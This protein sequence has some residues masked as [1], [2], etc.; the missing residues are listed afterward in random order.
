MGSQTRD[1]DISQVHI[2]FQRHGQA[3]SNIVD[4]DNPGINTEHMTMSQLHTLART[5]TGYLQTGI[6]LPDG[7]TQF[8]LDASKTFVDAVTPN[9]KLDN[10]YMLVSSPLTRAFQTIQGNAPAFN[11]VGPLHT[12]SPATLDPDF[13]FPQNTPSISK[14][15]IYVHAGLQEATTWPQDFP[16][17]IN[18]ST[19]TVSYLNTHGGSVTGK[20]GLLTTETTLPVNHLIWPDRNSS[21]C[22]GLPQ[23]TW[24]SPTERMARVLS[25]PSLPEIEEQVRQSRVWL[26]E[27]ATKV[28]LLHRASGRRG[29]PRMVVCLHGGIVNFVTQ[30]WYCDVVANPDYNCSGDG[31]GSNGQKWLWKGSAKLGNLECVVYRFPSQT[32]PGSGGV[33]SDGVDEAAIEEVPPQ[34]AAEE[35]EILGKYYRHL[36]SEVGIQDED[37]VEADGTMADQKSGHWE[38]IQAKAR[39][40]QRFAEERGDVL[41]ALVNWRGVDDFLSRYVENLQRPD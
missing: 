25:T 35:R 37:Y 17:L 9:G 5:K 38:F 1:I 39:D 27:A 32:S 16:P 36:S 21:S 19:N 4:F 13:P 30:R 12:A 26:R 34:E 3:I 24:Q 31:D 28:A 18:T 14:M 8:G 40:V 22:P 10:V 29:T 6:Y 11:L 41:E 20:K 7:L 33:D 15:K 2:I 23:S